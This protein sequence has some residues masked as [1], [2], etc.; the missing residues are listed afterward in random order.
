MK[1]AAKKLRNAADYTLWLFL[2]LLLL[3][4]AVVAVSKQLGFIDK[5]KEE[6]ESL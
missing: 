3:V 4:W 1:C 5:D 2:P 6:E